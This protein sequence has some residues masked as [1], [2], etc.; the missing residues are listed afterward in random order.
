ML[1][2]D[3]NFKQKVVSGLLEQ[4]ENFTGSDEAFARQW[5]IHKTIF[6]RIKNGETEKV[7]KDTQWINIGRELN[8]SLV[9]R[10]LKIVR[11]DVL[12]VIEEDIEFCQ[13]YSKA[14]IF[15][16]DSEIGKTVA[17]KYLSRKLTN[18]FYVDCSQAK[19]KNLFVRLL[20]K[21]I[22]ID[23]DG[24]IADIIANTIYYLRMLPN[25]CVILDEV[26]D[27]DP[28]AFLECKGYWNGTEGTCG[29]Y[30]IGADGLKALIEKGIRNKKVGYR[31]IFSRFSSSYT[32][33]TPVLKNEKKLFYTKLITDVVSANMEDKTKLNEIVGKCLKQ[34]ESGNIGGLRR[35][36]SILILN[37]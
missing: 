11:T 27:L 13:T 17:A 21:T 3:Q 33:V 12:S 23:S 15:V 30:M 7:L 2:I 26:A 32:T 8:I 35:A 14:R 28:K 29:W 22:G 25:P 4:R 18:C 31:E 19:S 20:A 9:D 6:S 5:N 37:S 24:K 10:K 34:D 1:Q 16:D 36:E